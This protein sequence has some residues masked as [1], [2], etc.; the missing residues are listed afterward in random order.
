MA[1]GAAVIWVRVVGDCCWAEEVVVVVVVVWVSDCFDLVFVGG[2]GCGFIIFGCFSCSGSW[3]QLF[4]WQWLFR[5]TMYRAGSSFWSMVSFLLFLRFHV[6]F[7][8]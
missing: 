6:I 3:F 5:H 8:F 4:Q 7:A 1:D 2:S